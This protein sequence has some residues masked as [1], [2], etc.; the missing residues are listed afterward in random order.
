MEQADTPGNWEYTCGMR[1]TSPTVPPASYSSMP[2][3]LHRR[4][5]WLWAVLTLGLPVLALGMML[6]DT[7]TGWGGRQVALVGLVSLQLALYLKT[8]VFP[9]P[10][11]LAR[12][13][14]RGNRG[15]G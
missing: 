3:R 9:H 14:R 8:F 15:V 13:R 5:L 6:W 11:P 4:Y 10:W 2:D 12:L 7:R 1:D